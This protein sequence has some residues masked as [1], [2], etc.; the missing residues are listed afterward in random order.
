M[1]KKDPKSVIT[2]LIVDC[3]SSGEPL[4]S[5]KILTKK[6]GVSRSRL[7]ELLIEFE[8][9]GMI[10]ATQGKGRMVQF[11]EVSN[12]I[13]DGW[14]ILL[15]A[16]PESLL[17]F[18]EVRYILER[19][20]LPSVIDSLRLEDLQMMR[21]LITRMEAKAKKGQVFKEEDQLFHQ[22]LY[23]RTDNIVLDQLLKTFWDLFEQTS[24]IHRSENLVEGAEI[25]R[26]LYEAILIQDSEE[27]EKLLEGQFNDV[28]E[29]IKTMINEKE[30]NLK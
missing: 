22:I 8:A 21:D 5:E 17:E 26:K 23:S 9:S 10:V 28:R 14:R 4:P 7:R 30:K 18:L 16:R 24:E 1:E 19:G 29:R 2:D 27:A 12:F 3:L 11:P 6:L 13:L 20:F 25:H 15:R